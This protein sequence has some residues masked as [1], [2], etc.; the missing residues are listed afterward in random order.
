MEHR[1]QQPE[2]YNSSTRQ[3]TTHIRRTSETR[4]ATETRQVYSTS[5]SNAY[6]TTQKLHT[7]PTN[8]YSSYLKKHSPIKATGEV[9]GSTERYGSKVSPLQYTSNQSHTERSQAS[10]VLR[11]I[12]GRQ[13]YGNRITIEGDNHPSK[14]LE[15]GTI[16]VETENVN[17][18]PRTGVEVHVDTYSKK[19]YEQTMPVGSYDELPDAY[20]V[21]SRGSYDQDY[22][23]NSR[24]ENAR[25]K[26]AELV[27]KILGYLRSKEE[28]DDSLLEDLAAADSV[29]TNRI[30]SGDSKKELAEKRAKLLR[31]IAEKK[32][33]I[34]ELKVP[35]FKA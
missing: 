20:E 34:N 4:P 1:Y 18:D 28:T 12:S 2:S 22:R 31:K 23:T 26:R 25:D 14:P 35:K 3:S 17:V 7:E 21:S 11:T 6:V 13:S 24:Y 29:P 9:R 32:R 16:L 5:N 33:D 30:S 8:Y 10:P 15:R 19:K 27:G